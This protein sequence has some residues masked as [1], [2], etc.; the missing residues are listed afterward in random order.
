MFKL[1]DLQ[2]SARN[3]KDIKTI[4]EF[5]FNHGIDLTLKEA[6]ELWEE[7]SNSWAAGFLYVDDST[8]EGFKDYLRDEHDLE[9]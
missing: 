2:V 9:I 4:K 6:E 5:M 1:K 8:L 3:F 7:F